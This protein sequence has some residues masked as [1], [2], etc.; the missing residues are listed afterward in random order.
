MFIH[1]HFDDSHYPQRVT[2]K[3]KQTKNKPETKYQGVPLPTY[4]RP[5]TKKHTLPQVTN[6]DVE[7][8]ILSSTL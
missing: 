6:L 8:Q 4:N 5:L 2:A 3:L 7:V 1:L